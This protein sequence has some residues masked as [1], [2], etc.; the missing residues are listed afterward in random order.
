MHL[1]QILLFLG[2]GALYVGYSGVMGV[3]IRRATHPERR[4]LDIAAVNVHGFFLFLPASIVLLGLVELSLLAR[5]MLIFSGVGVAAMGLIQP[6][7]TPDKLWK[8]RFGYRYFATAMAFA[9]IWGI[10][11]AVSSNS[12]PAAIIGAAAGLACAVSFNLT[13]PDATS[14]LR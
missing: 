3:L 13:L 8:R 11:L 4:A 14:P 10:G 12:L 5:I 1:Q 6:H 2:A 7:W 9:A